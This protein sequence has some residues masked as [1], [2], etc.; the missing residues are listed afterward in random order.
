MCVCVLKAPEIPVTAGLATA[1]DAARAVWRSGDIKAAPLANNVLMDR[2]AAAWSK[3]LKDLR[4]EVGACAA[5]LTCWTAG[6]TS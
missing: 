6:A 3:R 1:Y 5:W 2:D 4:A